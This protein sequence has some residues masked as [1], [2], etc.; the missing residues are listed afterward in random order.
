MAKIFRVGEPANDAEKW[1]FEYLRVNLDDSFTIITNVDVYSENNQ[2]FECDAIV[3]GTWGVYVI[4]VKGYKGKLSVGKD[5][6]T[7]NGREVANPLPKLNQNARVLASRCKKRISYNQHAPWCQSMVFITGGLGEDVSIE[8][9]DHKLPVYGKETIIDALSKSEYLSCQY[10]HK[11]ERYQKKVALEAICDFKLIK[12]RT[13]SISSFEKVKKIRCKDNIEY[14]TVK[15]Q[16]LSFSYE[17]SMKLVDLTGLSTE[18]IL[19]YRARFQKEYFILNELQ[20]IPSVPVPLA[21]HDDGEQL[22]IVYQMI[23]GEPLSSVALD[24]DTQILSI[25]KNVALAVTS[26]QSKGVFYRSLSLSNIYVNETEVEFVDV[27]LSRTDKVKTVVSAEQLESPW[28]AP[29][30]I[31]DNKYDEFSLSFSLATCF[32]KYFSENEPKSNST[33]EFIDEEYKFTPNTLV[34]TIDGLSDWFERAVEIES[35]ERPTVKELIALFSREVVSGNKSQEKFILKEQAIIRDKYVL[36]EC[37]G[38]GATSS[39]WKANYLTGGFTCCLKIL[40]EFTDSENFAIKE[41][42]ILRSLFHPNIIRIFDL[43]CIPNTNINYLCCQ[44]I[45]GETLDAYEF[46]SS[47]SIWNCF[48]EMLSA[49]Q[50]LHTLNI[51]HKDIKPQNIMISKDMSYLIDFNISSTTSRFL[52]SICYKDPTVRSNG[53][54]AF[55][56]IYSLVVSFCEIASKLHPFES[57]DGIPLVEN[58]IEL[59]KSPFIP[60]GLRRRFNQVLNRDIEWDGVKDY[61]AWFGVSAKIEIVIPKVLLDKWNIPRGYQTKIVSVMLGDLIPR[62]RTAIVRNTLKEYALV[63]NKTNKSSANSAISALKRLNVLRQNKTK[64]SIAKEFLIDWKIM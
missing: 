8:I 38:R 11:L 30:Y 29:E 42:E 26:M 64:M 19:S 10:K 28:L 36:E 41:F 40:E 22:A 55:S 44:Y 1:A 35:D 56:D 50:Y 32:L 31:L 59:P 5:V 7:F 16:G 34:S 4:D 45:D 27:G 21:F 9:R 15:P 39:I 46:N 6:W 51:I 43:D 62:S 60:D 14:W 47:F 23:E 58:D 63:G 48:R 61:S 2:P 37:V 24:D 52:G 17:Y 57:N 18:E 13:E 25:L 20:E 12:N 3:V 54:S 53:W 49:L 33:F